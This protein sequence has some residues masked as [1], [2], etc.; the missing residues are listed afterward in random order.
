M[1]K[2]KFSN[3]KK[4]DFN[5][6]PFNDLKGFVIS[7]LQKEEKA[8][9]AQKIPRQPI[10]GSFTDEMKMLGVKQLNDDIDTESE[11]SG[12]FL[13]S[14]HKVTTSR[15]QTEEDV[16]MAAMGDLSVKFKD[17]FPEED[18]PLAA[19]PKRMKQLKQGRLT[20]DAS[21]DLHG[22]KCVDVVERLRH[23]LKN[24][25]HQGWQTLLVITGKGLHSE[26][27][28]PVLR[29]EAERFLSGEGRKLVVEWGRA[30]KQY[31][32]DGALILFLRKKK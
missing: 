12:G 29:N 26:M 10:F 11:D 6:D 32:G 4:T 19:A 5:S 28:E 17:H 21:L 18:L 20:P 13:P 7:D 3:S 16:F 27:G 24:C 1:A 9:M 8:V 25:Q 23:F 14:D 30:P 2:K 31:G 15:E 22:F